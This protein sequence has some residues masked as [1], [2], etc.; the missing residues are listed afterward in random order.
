MRLT[1]NGIERADWKADFSKV[2]SQIRIWGGKGRTISVKE[3]TVR[4][5]KESSGQR[6]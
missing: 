1:V 2:N 3:I 6:S 5:P 4:R